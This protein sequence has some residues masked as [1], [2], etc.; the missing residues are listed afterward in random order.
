MTR[1]MRLWKT[2]TIVVVSCLLQAGIAWGQAG[3]GEINQ[4]L[5]DGT[6]GFPFVIDTPGSYIL[7]SNIFKPAS[8]GNVD[9]IRIESSNVSLNL[10]GFTVSSEVLCARDAF[11]CVVSCSG[12][13][14]GV[15]INETGGN[16]N[17]TIF[18]GTVSGFFTGVNTTG[19]NVEVRGMT[20]F[21][22]AFNGVFSLGFGT[23][24]RAVTSV[25]NG[26][27]GV[28]ISNDGFVLDS[29][30]ANN[31]AAG[32]VANP[33][34]TISRNLIDGNR[35]NGISTAPG[36]VYSQNTISGN[37]TDPPVA[38]GTDGGLNSC[39]DSNDVVV[40]CQ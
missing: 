17:V 5:I 25:R 23:I 6:G 27:S 1:T 35:G 13:A 32:I 4:A 10:R 28:A 8:V 12:G 39:T 18:G 29:T 3:Q 30:I 37:C 33:N 7:T 31:D 2:I 11:T 19:T 26:D 36:T 40:A 9:A 21:N 34:V 24:V 16:T 14:P 15:G 20:V 38:L 22:N